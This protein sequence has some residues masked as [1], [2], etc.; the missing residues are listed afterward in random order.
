MSIINKISSSNKNSKMPLEEK[1]KY[2]IELKESGIDLKNLPKDYISKDGVLINDVILDVHNFF[3]KNQM[4]VRQMITCE[5]LGIAFEVN[6][7]DNDYKIDYLKKAVQEGLML[8][9]ITSN[10]KEYSNNSIYQYIYD[11]RKKYD[12]NLLTEKQQESCI[13]ELKIVIPKE[14]IKNIL[15]KKIKDSAIKNII[16]QEDIKKSLAID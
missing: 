12:K 1:I 5:N 10:S 16:F 6:N 9:D 15:L 11:L 13:N 4:T 14:D 7:L 8:S 3:R 2:L